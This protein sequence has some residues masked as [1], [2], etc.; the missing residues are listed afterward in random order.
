[1]KPAA[2]GIAACYPHIFFSVDIEDM[3][4]RAA[5]EGEA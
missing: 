4:G 1:M 2:Q 3:T 5:F